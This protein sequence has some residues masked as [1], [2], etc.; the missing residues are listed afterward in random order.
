MRNDHE[1]KLDKIRFLLS[2]RQP[3]FN[4]AMTGGGIFDPKTKDIID[5]L[6][7]GTI[8]EPI[9]YFLQEEVKGFIEKYREHCDSSLRNRSVNENA[10][11]IFE[12]T[13]GHPIMVRFSVLKNGLKN[14]VRDMYQKWLLTTDNIPNI[15]RIKSVI[16]CSLY[17]ISSIPLTEDELFN[18]LDL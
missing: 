5:L 13:K 8:R 4:L 1:D 16:A 14:H 2:A 6:F 10:Q 9:T 3:D 17:D 11:A 7:D 15:E 18:K 12:D